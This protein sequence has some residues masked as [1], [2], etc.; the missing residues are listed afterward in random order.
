MAVAMTATN[1]CYAKS[2]LARKTRKGVASLRSVFILSE[3]L[4]LNL[5]LGL[6]VTAVTELAWSLSGNQG[7]NRMSEQM[8][9]MCINCK[10]TMKLE[11]ERE[12][13]KTMQAPQYL[14]RVDNY[15][16]DKKQ[17]T[18]GNCYRIIVGENTHFGILTH[19][20]DSQI[21]FYV[22]AAGFS[23]GVKSY[24]ISVKDILLEY[25]KIEEL[26]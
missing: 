9:M 12:L 23:T 14:E 25:T 19:V 1:S 6:C 13:R 18:L 10:G 5:K 24:K 8:D 15:I 17:L 3:V 20:C 22:Y 16:F 7:G 21:D 2:K 26:V 4:R 11:W